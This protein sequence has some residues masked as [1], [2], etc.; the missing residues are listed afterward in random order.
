M[1]A[2]FFITCR[3]E[4]YLLET[5]EKQV[6]KPNALMKFLVRDQVVRA[7]EKYPI[8]APDVFLG[9]LVRDQTI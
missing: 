6:Y 2:K 1:V 9:F 8:W 7:M 5:R 3:R 4:L